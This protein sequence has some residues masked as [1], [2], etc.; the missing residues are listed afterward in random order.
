MKYIFLTI[1]FFCTSLTLYSQSKIKINI[2]KNSEFGVT[3]RYPNNWVPQTSQL[4]STL[5]LLYEKNGSLSTCNLSVI[6][7]DKNNIDDYDSTYF[8]NNFLKVFPKIKNLTNNIEYHLGQRVS[9]FTFESKM[10]LTNKEVDLK[11]F[12]VIFLKN[13]NRFMFVVNTPQKNY[14]KI[15]NDLNI[16]Y[17]TLMNDN[18][19]Q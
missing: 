17:G 9:V 1:L 12:L 5:I 14:I 4:N 19:I 13:D 7:K 8:K 3:F 11:T 18:S 16:M 15:I 10:K 2:F 6:K